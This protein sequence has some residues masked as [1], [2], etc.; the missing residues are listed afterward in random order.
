V[1]RQQAEGE[2]A[3]L[4]GELREKLKQAEAAAPGMKLK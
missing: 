1:K 2:L 3:K 4:E